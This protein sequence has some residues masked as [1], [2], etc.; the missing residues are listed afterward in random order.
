MKK[1]V[2]LISFF[3]SLFVKAQEVRI[4]NIL[5]ND[6]YSDS[7]RDDRVKSPE[8]IKEVN[9]IRTEVASGEVEEKTFWYENGLYV[10]GIIKT[11]EDKLT[12]V[13][14]YDSIGRITEIKSNYKDIPVTTDSYN[15]TESTKYI[16]HEKTGNVETEAYEEGKL[17]RS[18]MYKIKD[19]IIQEYAT[20]GAGK[21]FGIK[22]NIYLIN[23]YFQV[24]DYVEGIK[25][26][27]DCFYEK[28]D[29]IYKYDDK[30][31]IISLSD[32]TFEH[33]FFYKDTLL[34]SSKYSD[35][36]YEYQE[37]N[38]YEY[39]AQGNWIKKIETENGKTI[40]ITT[41]TIKYID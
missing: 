8:K 37:E 29:I 27:K 33:L 22:N 12:Y 10:K 13:H 39:D 6:I 7:N 9:A 32:D 14:S 26:S 41:R 18:S 36:T 16:Y 5:F 30:E 40:Y 20:F 17:E 35:K 31:R 38:I 28:E 34:V 23:T 19:G 2:L 15:S 4:E 25:T 24:W 21:L 3:V 1:Y 11:A